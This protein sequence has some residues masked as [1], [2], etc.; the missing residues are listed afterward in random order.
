MSGGG[1]IAPRW[2][3]W[4]GLVALVAGVVLMV[5]PLVLGS[6]HPSHPAAG[7]ALSAQDVASLKRG[8][9]SIDALPGAIAEVPAAMVR[10]SGTSGPV[11][12][13]EIKALLAKHPELGPLERSIADPSSLTV[14]LRPALLV[15][16]HRSGSH[17]GGGI[18]VPFLLL[19]STLPGAVIAAGGLVLLRRARRG[20]DLV[21]STRPV[22]AL[23]G[24][25][26]VVAVV[27]A[28]VPAFHSTS[29]VWG[30]SHL[31]APGPAQLDSEL[32]NQQVAI[33]EIIPA[34]EDGG[35][36]GRKLIPPGNAILLVGAD[37]ARAA[38]SR[39]LND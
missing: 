4:R 19:V 8:V 3:P 38:L 14:G 15:S 7:S 32:S 13:A 18:S 23:I 37:P 29:T 27:A 1:W 20:E 22:L 12:T 25:A 6:G 21:G 28:L 5:L 11:I 30:G 16:L 39:V 17:A 33:D 34:I 26:G 35:L 24:V 9:A 10:A 2:T 31:A 36:L